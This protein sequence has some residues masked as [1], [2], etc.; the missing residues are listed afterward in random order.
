MEVPKNNIATTNL[1]KSTTQCNLALEQKEKYTD[2]TS[3]LVPESIDMTVKD[4]ETIPGSTKM[5]DNV[6][7]E[8][9]DETVYEKLYSRSS[10]SSRNSIPSSD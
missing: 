2:N 5:R 9:Q 8:I 7:D 4:D 10:S 6:Q 1:E 3:V